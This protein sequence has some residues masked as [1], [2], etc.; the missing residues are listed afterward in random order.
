MRLLHVL[1][2]ITL[3]ICIH[4]QEADYYDK[5]YEPFASKSYKENIKTVL[6]YKTPYE[7]LEPVIELRSEDKLI[8]KFDDLD[9]DIK[10]YSY[11]II[12]CSYDWKESDIMDHQYINGYMDEQLTDYQFSFN[13]LQSFTHYQLEFPSDNLQPKISGNYVIKVFQDFDPENIVLMHRFRIIQTKVGVTARI[14]RTFFSKDRPKGHELDFEVNHKNYPIDNP[15]ADLRVVITQN[16]RIDNVVTNLMPT[17][18][19]EGQIYYDLD[20]RN[21]F[22]AGNQYRWVDFR[23]LRF[24]TKFTKLITIEDKVN[25]VYLNE[26]EERWG[27]LLKSVYSDYDGKFVIKIQEGFND[28]I[29]ADYAKIH[30]KLHYHEPKKDGNFYLVGGFSNWNL[31]NEN[32]LVY[33]KDNSY[34]ETTQYLKQGFY[35]YEYIFVKN[36]EKKGDSS[37]IEGSYYDTGNT[38]AIYVYHRKWGSEYDEL[39][40]LRFLN[41]EGLLK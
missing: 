35:N 18:I 7:D 23:S 22:I 4:S 38:Y 17:I 6:L 3:P 12:H 29:E 13:T 2:L 5:Y 14:N 8:L 11:T 27:K 28:H 9:G 25:H 16:N 24:L 40:G 33:N 19:H 1:A 41:T 31:S 26:D 15:N 34:Y 21:E 36:N 37:V 10:D 20:R 30:F 39:V 32:M